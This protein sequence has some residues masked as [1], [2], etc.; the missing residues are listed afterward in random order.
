M[1]TNLPKELGLDGLSPAEQQELT[2]ELGE[3]ILSEIERRC[4][5]LLSRK[6]RKAYDKLAR[7]DAVA[8]FALLEQ[9]IPTFAAIQQEATAQVQRETVDMHDAVMKKLGAG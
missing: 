4:K 7:T 6:Q 8:A 2:E 3:S 5:P 9:S 1:E